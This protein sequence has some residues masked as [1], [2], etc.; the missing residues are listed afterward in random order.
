MEK[1][2]S[3]TINKMD[4]PTKGVLLFVGAFIITIGLA[5]CIITFAIMLLMDTTSCS[6][7]ARALAVLLITIAVVFITSV[8][9]AGIVARKITQSTPGCVALLVAHGAALLA[10]YLVIGFGLLVAF[11]C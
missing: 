3:E 9:V 8:V 6:T 1:T 5:C 11:N 10:S 7:M 2:G 4:A